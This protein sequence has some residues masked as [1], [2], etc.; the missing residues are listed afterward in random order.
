[1]RVGFKREVD[2]GIR[3]SPVVRLRTPY[4][5]GGYRFCECKINTGT[6]MQLFVSQL[7]GLVCHRSGDDTNSKNGK[8]EKNLFIINVNRMDPGF[9]Q[10]FLKTA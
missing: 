1:M 7:S 4:I 8:W 9:G 3:S 2:G 5:R 6:S 10:I